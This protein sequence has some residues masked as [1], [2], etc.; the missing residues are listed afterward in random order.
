MNKIFV[1]TEKS[2]KLRFDWRSQGPHSVLSQGFEITGALAT[3]E[4]ANQICRQ[5]NYGS[6]ERALDAHRAFHSVRQAWGSSLDWSLGMVA[7]EALK[8]DLALK[9]SKRLR[10]F[11]RGA[12]DTGVHVLRRA[13]TVDGETDFATVEVG[14]FPAA[15]CYGRTLLVPTGEVSR[16]FQCELWLRLDVEAPADDRSVL[17]LKHMLFASE[18]GYSLAGLADV[19]DR[20]SDLPVAAD[21]LTSVLGTGYDVLAV[22]GLLFEHWAM[23]NEH[24]GCDEFEVDLAAASSKVPCHPVVVSFRRAGSSQP[25]TLSFLLDS[26]FKVPFAYYRASGLCVDVEEV[27]SQHR[28]MV[29]ACNRLQKPDIIRSLNLEH[30]VDHPERFGELRE[31]V[32]SG[33]A[34]AAIIE[35]S[36][37]A[38]ARFKADAR[39]GLVVL[40]HAGRE[41]RLQLVGDAVK[42]EVGILLPLFLTLSARHLQVPTCY[43][44]MHL[45]DGH[46]G[47]PTVLDVETAEANTRRCRRALR[48]SR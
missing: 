33:T 31:A 32:E 10:D 21:A 29:A 17:M 18:E 5:F 37:K 22:N 30:F 24:P 48:N 25:W 42:T 13:V 28:K 43:M 2:L 7:S 47:F 1:Q 8:M 23:H 6:G 36:V 38:V 35:E 15:D 9:V 45:R 40:Y 12:P 39:T 3:P 41:G 20:I 44:V 11:L 19:A 16:R 34:F 26:D 14:R 27:Q 46:I 4:L